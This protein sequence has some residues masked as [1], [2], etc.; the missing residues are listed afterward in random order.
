MPINKI[1]SEKGPFPFIVAWTDRDLSPHVLFNSTVKLASECRDRL[2]RD[3]HVNVTIF[4]DLD[5]IVETN[6]VP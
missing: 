3:G 6:D 5:Y 1:W 4:L 2:V